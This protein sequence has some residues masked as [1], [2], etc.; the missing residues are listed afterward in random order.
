MTKDNYNVIYYYIY[1][2]ML[3]I[4][5]KESKYV[6]GIPYLSPLDRG[7]SNRLT[8]LPQFKRLHNSKFFS[9]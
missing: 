5:L 6:M 7:N 1:Y 4:Q 9:Q 2:Q 3:P 8:N